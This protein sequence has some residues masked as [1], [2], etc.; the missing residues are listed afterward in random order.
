MRTKRHM[1]AAAVAVMLTVAVAA[2][3]APAAG[4]DDGGIVLR[5]DGSKAVEVVTVREPAH[6][7]DGFDWGD[8]GF[9]ASGGVAVL[10]L[11]GAGAQ[12]ARGRHAGR[13]SP[14]AA[15]GS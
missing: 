11:A 8:A 14:L 3:P 1:P 6:Q 4:E 10:L 15:P 5:R 12:V 7:A 2:P 9:G 13:R